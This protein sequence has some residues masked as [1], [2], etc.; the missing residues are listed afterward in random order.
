MGA[1]RKPAD[2]EKR[3]VSLRRYEILDT[4]RERDFDEIVWLAS[5]IC[6][7][8]IAAI[9]LVDDNRQW[10]KAERG[11]GT[12]QTERSAAFCAH[13][14][15]DDSP[16]VVTDATDDPRFADNPL[17]TAPPSL[18]FYAG[19]PI[20]GG[21]FKLGTLCV[22]DRIPRA[23]TDYQLRALSVLS[24]Q[25]E[26]QLELRL[27]ATRLA[28]VQ[29]QK[30]ELASLL[31][32]D[33]KN[34]LSSMLMNAQ[35]IAAGDGD[36]QTARSAALDIE[37]GAENMQS[38]ISNMLEV[39]RSDAGELVPNY[40]TVS[41][42]GLL[43]E[44]EKAMARR[45]DVTGQRLETQ[46]SVEDDR[47]EIDRSLVRRLIENLVDN[48]LRYSRRSGGIV[49]IAVGESEPGF[50]DIAVSDEGAGVPEEMRTRIFERYARIDPQ[51]SNNQGRTGFG[52]GL[53][54]CRMIAEAHRGRIWVENHQ[55]RG[56]T[57]RVR[58]PRRQT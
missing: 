30:D 56:S 55:P 52:L 20:F 19:M 51:L 13:A 44:T 6:D 23:I 3:L 16:F 43:G 8:P 15:L 29:R 57:F 14:I 53:A 32:H 24:R 50:V 31:V 28:A 33:M 5:T 45:A 25:V 10:F 34:P 49:E 37:V 26:V 38:M 1:A 17:V 54:S 58:L 35:F 12:R 21:G 36:E 48:A 22:L 47:V 46:C 40:E 42:R 27:H 39:A 2:E 41:L 9:S 18:R 4:P 7:A 11:L